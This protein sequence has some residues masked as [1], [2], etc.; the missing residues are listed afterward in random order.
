MRYILVF[1]AAISATVALRA[2]SPALE[3]LVAEGKAANSVLRQ[4]QI[5]LQRS[6]AA[7]DEARSMFWP[8]LSFNAN[9]TRAGG[10]RSIQLPVGDLL[11]PVYQTLNQLTGSS[12]FPQ[13]E[14]VSENFLPNNFHETR[15]RLI[16]PI[17]NN[18]LYFNYQAKKRLVTLQEAQ[19]QAYE[20]TLTRD[21][22]VAYY[23]YLQSEEAVRIYAESRRLLEDILQ[24]NQ[25]LYAN[26]KVSRDAL[27][28]AEY[29]LAKLDGESAAATERRQMARAYVNFLVNRK[30]ETPIERDSISGNSQ[31]ALL[32]DSL[33]WYNRAE[34]RQLDAARDVAG[35]A[36]EMQRYASLPK[37][38]LAAEGGFQGF[39]YTFDDGQDYWLMQLSLSWDLFHGFQRRAKMEQARLDIQ[40]IDAR[41][42]QIESQLKLQLQQSLYALE[43]ATAALE[44]AEAALRFA[45]QQYQSLKSRYDQQQAPA[46]ELHAARQNLSAAALSLNIARHTLLIRYA[47]LA[48]AAGIAE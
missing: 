45:R 3:R 17:L 7:L 5:Q 2:Q 40:S 26:Q 34:L 10:G 37:L 11:N 13:I 27:Y 41:R 24:L 4:E 38:N 8:L 46:I 18:E 42:N 16:Q 25:R 21:I 44:S 12:Q 32:S 33:A 20:E 31:P 30:L 36:F 9:Y 6:M 35:Q 29:E 23:Q 1:I 22:K 48:Y 43:T 39:G 28:A 19:K 14:N 15:F 47:E